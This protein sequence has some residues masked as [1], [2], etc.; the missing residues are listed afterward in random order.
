MALYMGNTLGK[1][2]YVKSVVLRTVTIIAVISM[3]MISVAVQALVNPGSKAPS[4]KLQSISGKTVSLDEF[5][6]DPAKKGANR[7]VVLVFWATWCPTCREET[8]VLQRLQEKYGKKGMAVLTVAMDKGGIKDVKPFAKEHKL[9]YRMLVDP[10]NK[11]IGPLYYSDHGIPATF[12]IDKQGVVRYHHV[13]A[14]PGY[15]KMVNTEVAS[16]LN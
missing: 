11:V 8:Q 1:E 3:L 13:G 15:E 16:L 6:K 14:I 10:D 12:I 9:T 7:V 5:R 4:F 2:H